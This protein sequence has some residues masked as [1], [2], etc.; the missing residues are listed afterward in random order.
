MQLLESIGAVPLQADAAAQNYQECI[1]APRTEEY[2]NFVATQSDETR[3]DTTSPI[4][5][6]PEGVEVLS[7]ATIADSDTGAVD[8]PDPNAPPPIAYKMVGRAIEKVRIYLVGVATNMTLL[9]MHA[10]F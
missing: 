4:I 2:N 6:G 1:T 9:M 8:D 7:D 3:S 5:Q 10:A